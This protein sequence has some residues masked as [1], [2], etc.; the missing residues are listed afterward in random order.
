MAKLR[1]VYW[2]PRLRNLAKKVR[3]NCWGC[4]RFRA[5]AYEDPL[6][7][8]LPTTRTQGDTPYQAVGVDFAGPIKNRISAKTEGK[9]YLVL[10]ACYLARGVYL[11]LLPGLETDKFLPCLKRF[12]ARRGRP[13]MIYSDNGSTF[14][15]AAK[16]LY[17]VQ[18]EEKFHNVFAELGIVW[19]FNLS[20]APGGGVNFERLIGVFKSAFYKAVGN[21]TLSWNELSELVLDVEATINGRPLSY[22]E[23]DIEML[24]LTP[25]SMLYLRPD[26]LPEL[27][28]HQIQEPDLRS[29]AV[30]VRMQ[31]GQNGPGSIC[32]VSER[33][34]VV[35][36]ENRPHI[37]RLEMS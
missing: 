10:F 36:G 13:S 12:I 14:Q 1:D 29:R 16:W 25:S 34:I 33:D 2:V 6:P 7:G 15:A 37:Q 24:V 21:G 9:A 32:Q 4:K 17:K 20:R 22:L 11:D 35:V 23:G 28:P 8:D 18:E 19:R 5:K 3:G 30:A 26:Q 31:C 27:E